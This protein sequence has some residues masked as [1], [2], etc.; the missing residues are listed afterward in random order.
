MLRA[1]FAL[2]DFVDLIP[3]R[4]ARNQNA[5]QY[6][7][8]NVAQNQ[9]GGEPLVMKADAFGTSY[10]HEFLELAGFLRSDAGFLQ[11]DCNSMTQCFGQVKMVLSRS[12]LELI[13]RSPAG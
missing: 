3:V 11:F 12:V 13:A 1:C 6:Y 8:L 10:V 2:V 9:S 4:M 7:R 5:F